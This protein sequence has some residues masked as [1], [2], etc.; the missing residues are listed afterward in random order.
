MKS[1]FECK[2]G[3]SL[4]AAQKYLCKEQLREMM[5]KHLEVFKCETPL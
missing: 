5:A 1:E 2:C 4:K 3:Y